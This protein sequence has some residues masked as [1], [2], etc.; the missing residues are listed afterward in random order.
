MFRFLDTLGQLCK[1]LLCKYLADLLHHSVKEVF[2]RIPFFFLKLILHQKEYFIAR[3]APL[4]TSC[5]H[6]N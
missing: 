5:F 4:N 6:F 1:Y 2:T 3:G